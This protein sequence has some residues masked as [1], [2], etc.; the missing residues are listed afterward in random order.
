MYKSLDSTVPTSSVEL[1][2]KHS[3]ISAERILRKRTKQGTALYD[4]PESATKSANENYNPSVRCPQKHQDMVA[5]SGAIQ[6]SVELIPTTLWKVKLGHR[7]NFA[8]SPSG[9][10][11]LFDNTKRDVLSDVCTA[12]N[13]FEN[14]VL[15]H[16]V[17][18]QTRSTDFFILHVTSKQMSVSL[19]LQAAMIQ[20]SRYA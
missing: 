15:L 13:S 14:G 12:E 18:N 4:D 1:V 6:P 7:K 9:K 10:T 5:S 11:S 3:L 8:I 16:W 17:C 20:A 19:F 2:I